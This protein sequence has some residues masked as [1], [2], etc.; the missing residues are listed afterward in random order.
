MIECVRRSS[1]NVK[2]WQSGDM[3]LP[4]EALRSPTPDRHTRTAVAKFHDERDVLLA[5]ALI[6]L[7]P[8][9]AVSEALDEGALAVGC[10]GHGQGE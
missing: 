2:R 8:Y 4:R 3:A 6:E 10:A 7:P 9:D 5:Q 1:R